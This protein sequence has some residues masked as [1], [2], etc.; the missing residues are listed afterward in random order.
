MTE[1]TDSATAELQSLRLPE[2]QARYREAF[3][4]DTRCPNRTYLI[5]KISKRLESAPCAGEPEALLA[6]TTELDHAVALSNEDVTELDEAVSQKLERDDTVTE[7]D[8]T[9]EAPPQE[10]DVPT[11]PDSAPLE[12][13]LEHDE[14]PTDPDPVL[15]EGE[16]REH[17]VASPQG[18]QSPEH[19]PVEVGRASVQQPDEDDEPRDRARKPGRRR[20]R[21]ASMTVE[22]LQ[23]MY[24]ATVGRP[25]SSRHVG[26]LQWKIREAER[27]R[28]PVGPRKERTRHGEP[29]DI[30]VLPL[31]LE[32]ETVDAIDEAWRKRGMKTRMEF[33]RRALG[34]YL[35]HLGASEVAARVENGSA[36]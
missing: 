22:D 9:D 10:D 21:F 5:R 4:E 36:A 17:E 28:V 11:E 14:E 12:P 18:E 34:H 27:G 1:N 3:G 24:L 20:G 29:L 2:L 7:H 15:D 8:E 32:A 33:L 19:A 13:P 30:K 25:S 23:A 31:R 16:P 26:Y 6:S 35:E